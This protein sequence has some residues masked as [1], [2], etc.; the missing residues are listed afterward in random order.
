MIATISPPERPSVPELMRSRVS[1]QIRKECRRLAEDRAALEPLVQTQ[2]LGLQDIPINPAL[3]KPFSTP[4]DFRRAAVVDSVPV[5]SSRFNTV[6]Q[7]VGNPGLKTEDLPRGS[8]VE[9][10]VPNQ[11]NVQI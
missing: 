3:S 2:V 1:P 4:S 9:N 8:Q 7:T 5:G 6:Q 10:L 11:M